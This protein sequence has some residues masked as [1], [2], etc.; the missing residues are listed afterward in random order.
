MTLIKYAAIALVLAT[1]TAATNIQCSDA[2]PR[3]AA[4]PYG[5]YRAI[6]GGLTEAQ[7]EVYQ[8]ALAIATTLCTA[9]STPISKDIDDEMALEMLKTRKHDAL[10]QLNALRARTT[11]WPEE[12]RRLFLDSMDRF[13]VEITSII[14]KQIESITGTGTAPSR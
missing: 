14:D 11:D 6:T 12:N 9:A 5:L 2:Q 10:A 8:Q 1:V 7:K 4:L 13:D 3:R